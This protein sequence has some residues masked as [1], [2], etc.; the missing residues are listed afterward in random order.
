MKNLAKYI[1]KDEKLPLLPCQMKELQKVFLA[2]NGDYKYTD[3]I[4]T[5]LFEFAHGPK[6]GS[7]HQSQQS[8]FGL[9]L[10]AWKPLFGEGPVSTI[11]GEHLTLEN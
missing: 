8:Y 9:I 4:M 5:Y 11:T 6:P 10:D 2:T 7:S 3:K 1:V